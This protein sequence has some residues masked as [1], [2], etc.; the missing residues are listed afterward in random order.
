[1]N[2]LLNPNMIMKR[3]LCHWY[4]VMLML[5]AVE[6]NNRSLMIWSM[7]NLKKWVKLCRRKR[8]REAYDMWLSY[9]NRCCLMKKMV[10]GLCLLHK[11]S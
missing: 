2:I 10:S 1:M 7:K 3:Y 11:L 6:F 8:M 5:R 4:E 9:Y